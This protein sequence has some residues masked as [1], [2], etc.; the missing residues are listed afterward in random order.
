MGNPAE[1]T[2]LLTIV[3]IIVLFGPD[4]DLLDRNIRVLSDLSIPIVLYDNTP[5][6]S[7]SARQEWLKD[8]PIDVNLTYLCD[9][10]N[11]GVAAAYNEGIRRYLQDDRVDAFLTLDQDTVLDRHS[12][13]ALL[14]SYTAA[15]SGGMV[16]VLGGR[17]VRSDGTG[18]RY[19]PASQRKIHGRYVDALL[20]ISSFSIVSK[21]SIREVGLFQEDFFIDH[22]DYDFC[23]RCKRAGFRTLIDEE[24][25]F[26]HQVG[27]GD[28]RF[29]GR[30]IC[31]IAHPFRSYYQVRNT[32][33]SARRGGAPLL[34]TAGEVVKRFVVVILNG[35]AERN[36]VPRL[37]YAVKGLLHGTRNIAGKLSG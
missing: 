6:C 36:L 2:N 15:S 24:I 9:G 25:P 1:N 32:I 7:S 20:V 11:R 30:Y 16:G 4:R 22:V 8:S 14:A 34:W 21:A 29:F 17:P 18:Y 37:R 10:R 26:V 31:P 3:A 19:K 28:V 12:L 35:F 5:G 23:W 27:T 33:L 13:A